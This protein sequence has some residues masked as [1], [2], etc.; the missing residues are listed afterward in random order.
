MRGRR[1]S[2]QLIPSA[3][4][5]L[6]PRVSLTEGRTTPHRRGASHLAICGPHAGSP[7]TEACNLRAFRRQDQI[8]LTYMYM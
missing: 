7:P 5:R 6:R 4:H 8:D 3:D 2:L 1:A